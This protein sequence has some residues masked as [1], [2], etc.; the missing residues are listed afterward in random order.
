MNTMK[1]DGPADRR[2]VP[3]ACVVAGLVAGTI[4]I[5]AASLVAWKNPLFILRV[6]A[7]GLLGR[8]AVGGGA[9]TELVGLLLQ[10]GMSILIATV[11]VA[12]ALRL[13]W[14]RRYPV[15]SGLAFGVLVFVAMNY[16]VV[17]L[18]ALGPKPPHFSAGSFAGNF[19]AMLLF[20][21]VISWLTGRQLAVRR[22][23][24]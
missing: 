17:P 11:F 7:A 16:I 10:W 1:L 6:V 8:D 23:T 21:L 18:S 5:F 20:G 13:A 4:D 19:L 24:G 15:R 9:G 14:M 22:A 12:A 2:A 3:H